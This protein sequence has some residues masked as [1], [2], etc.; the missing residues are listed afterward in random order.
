MKKVLVLMG[1]MSEEREVSLNSGKGVYEALLEKGYAP[2]K[3]AFAGESAGGGLCYCLLL[4][5]KEL[6]L[7]MPRCA[8][9]MASATPSP[10]DHS[11]RR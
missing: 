8:V 11:S 6:G 5:C 2:E 9:S 1:G 10:Y 7:P 3:I 4:K